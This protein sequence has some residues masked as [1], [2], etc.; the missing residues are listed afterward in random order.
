MTKKYHH[1]GHLVMGLVLK[2][3]FPLELTVRSG[4]LQIASLLL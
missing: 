4:S 3:F 2:G 1:T